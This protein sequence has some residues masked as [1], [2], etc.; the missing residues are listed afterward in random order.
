MR[1]VLALAVLLMPGCMSLE[2]APPA[3]PA[4]VTSIR[5]LEDP[6]DVVMPTVL[7][8]PIE[9]QVQVDEAVEWV[10]EAR[11]PGR[12]LE[13]RHQGDLRG[14]YAALQSVGSYRIEPRVVDADGGVVATAGA[15][16]L[17]VTHRYQGIP[18]ECDRVPQS[19]YAAPN[20]A[21][22]PLLV[23]YH[24]GTVWVEGAA[25][26]GAHQA[27][28]PCPYLAVVDGMGEQWTRTFT[29]L[30]TGTAEIATPYWSDEPGQVGIQ[31]FPTWATGDVS[32]DLTVY[33][34]G[35]AAGE[36]LDGC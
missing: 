6:G 1:A 22:A 27:A 2:T 28:A 19:E 17:N 7:V 32:Y 35:S 11:L 24:A 18:V 14:L 13:L 15:K 34:V 21:C 36:G 4:F 3:D 31:F 20:Y 16:A 9:A 33:P 23:P 26:F 29:W 5:W 8:L 30:N 12:G 25:H 10:V